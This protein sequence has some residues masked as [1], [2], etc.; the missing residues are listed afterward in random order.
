M[1]RTR[2][3]KP[4]F[5]KNEHL[6]AIDPMARLFF[7]GLWCLADRDG[8]IKWIPALVKAELFPYEDHADVNG[9]LTVISR[10]GHVKMY[11]SKE[12]CKYLHIT[13]WHKHQRP[14]H[15]E[16]PSEIQPLFDNGELTV[17]SPLSN[18]GNPPLVP[19]NLS[20][21]V[22]LN[23]EGNAAAPPTSPPPPFRSVGWYNT[24]ADLQRLKGS[25]SWLV[26]VKPANKLANTPDEIAPVFEQWTA[27]AAQYGDLLY[28]VA[29]PMAPLYKSVA[30]M[31]NDIPEKLEAAKK[32]AIKANPH[33]TVNPI[34]SLDEL[35]EA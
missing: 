24:H 31:L 11:A 3:I 22:P 17:I 34:A 12:G 16:K 1:A 18:G 26:W 27:L 15:T 29:T 35:E 13:N 5:F 28:A 9:Y 6:G 32:A 20:T 2:Y 10:L 19:Y 21:L 8:W 14:H 4:G 30:Q 23:G 33:E 7:V 25:A